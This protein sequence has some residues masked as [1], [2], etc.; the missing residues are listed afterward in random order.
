MKKKV[1]KSKKQTIVVAGD[2]TID[3][4][5]WGVEAQDSGVMKGEGR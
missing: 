5:Q 4:L 2:V 1:S 3:W